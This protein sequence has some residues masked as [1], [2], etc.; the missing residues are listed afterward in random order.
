MSRFGGKIYKN[1]DI[2]K[3]AQAIETNYHGKYKL[4][5]TIQFS[6]R[7]EKQKMHYHQAMKIISQDLKE[8]M[9]KNFKKL[10]WYV[11]FIE[12]TD[13][14]DSTWTSDTRLNK[15]EIEKIKTYIE[16]RLAEFYPNN[17]L[18]KITAV[19]TEVN[20]E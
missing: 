12:H 9:V 14:V 2:E 10:H 13:I 8:F 16:K 20:Y 7:T 19:T 6:G 4:H 15:S 3:L 18:K 5:I 17:Y 1:S 11:P